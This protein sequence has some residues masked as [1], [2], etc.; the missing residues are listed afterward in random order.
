MRKTSRTKENLEKV[1]LPNCDHQ[2]LGNWHSRKQPNL[3]YLSPN[4]KK[5]FTV[6]LEDTLFRKVGIYVKLP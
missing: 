3:S 2:S 1:L 5:D 6:T 4:E